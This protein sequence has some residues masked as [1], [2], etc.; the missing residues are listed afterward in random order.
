MVALP[1]DGLIHSML[2]L[3]VI[4]TPGRQHGVDAI[5]HCPHRIREGT[6]H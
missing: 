5:G 6:R 2:I 1:L 4:A 3:P